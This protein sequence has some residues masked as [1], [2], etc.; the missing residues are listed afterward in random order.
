MLHFTRQLDLGF[1][2]LDDPAANARLVLEIQRSLDYCDSHLDFGRPS[3]IAVVPFQDAGPS[4]VENISTA[5]GLTTGFFEL[6]QF[7]NVPALDGITAPDWIALGGA[8]RVEE[9]KL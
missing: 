1:S 6:S 5:I 9:R 4:F 3:R 7:V 8:L 2:Q